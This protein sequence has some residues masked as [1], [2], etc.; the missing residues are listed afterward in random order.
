MMYQHLIFTGGRDQVAECL[1]STS[2]KFKTQYGEKNG[3]KTK[4]KTKKNP[5]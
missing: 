3:Q 1:A 2:L 5:I 4:T